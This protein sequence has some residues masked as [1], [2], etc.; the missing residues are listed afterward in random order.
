MKD[1]RI[2]YVY[3]EVDGHDVHTHVKVT[4]ADSHLSLKRPLVNKNLT[5]MLWLETCLDMAANK[6]T[7]PC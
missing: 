6:R 7:K 4:S 1:T 5:C 3:V 2:S